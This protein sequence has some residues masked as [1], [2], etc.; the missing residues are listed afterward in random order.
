MKPLKEYLQSF[1]QQASP[2]TR[3]LEQELDAL[4]ESHASLSAD[5]AK[6]QED[7]QRA[8]EDDAQLL[9]GLQRQLRQIES[10]HAHAREQIEHLERSLAEAEQRQAS[11]EARTG[12]L[13][14]RLDE[15]HSSARD[16]VAQVQRLLA[17]AEQRQASTEAHVGSLQ[18]RLE[19][20]RNR[21]EAGLHATEA[22]LARIQDEQQSLLAQQSTL[23]NTLQGVATRLQDSQQAD[24]AKPPQS[25]LMLALIAGVLLVTGLMAGVFIMQGQQEGSKGLAMVER[26]IR[27][28]RVF[29]K[30]HID[31][32]EAALN[33]FAQALS[34]QDTGEQALAAPPPPARETET[35]G[36]V[37]QPPETVSFTPD[38]RELQASLM[39]LGFDLGI[40]KPNGEPGMKTRQALQEFRQ[41]YLPNSGTQDDLVSEPLGALILNSADL[42]RADAARFN[43]RSDVLAAI[44]LGSI[45]TGVD[46]SFLMELARV[47][48][49]FNPAAR[50]PRSSATGLFQFR[51]HAWLEAIRSFGPDY[52][53]QD[54]AARLELI[55]DGE[56]AQHRIVRDPLQ[57]EVLA[58]RLNP[59]L[60][61]LM[62]AENIKRNLQ[63]LSDRIRQEPGRTDLYL[64]HFLGPDGAVM[65]L[66]KLDREPAAIAADIFPQQAEGYPGVFQSQRQQ[67]RTVDDVYRRFER[68]FNTARYD[69]RY[70]G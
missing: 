2:Y 8:R 61:T 4:R 34:R 59:R 36:A 65:F 67:P 38:I 58:L 30:A 60:S 24:H 44:R 46:F 15:E 31:S 69:E 11:T 5:L 50:A 54:Y 12:S 57:L 29:M 14:T 41:F 48:S 51:D 70:P 1:R 40:S 9:A 18:T 62:V 6:S 28:M 56:Y 42:A 26:D 53:L 47:E 7:L 66:E 35:Q 10:E 3:A 63:I 19:E 20:E 27:D 55:D 52:G 68:W 21:H 43:I 64:A 32:Q 23:A 33:E 17:D 13:E 16:Q 45:R 39:S 25:R 49:D 37:D 22:S